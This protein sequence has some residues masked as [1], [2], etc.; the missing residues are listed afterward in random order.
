MDHMDQNFIAQHWYASIYDQFENFTHDVAFLLKV[1]S[2]QTDRKSLKIL[3]VACGTGRICIPLAEAGHAV[4]G[5]DLSEAALLRCLAKGKDLPNLTLYRADA[6]AEGWG[7]GYDVVVLA[8]NVFMNIEGAGDYA[9]AQRLF[10]RRA[11]DALRSGGHLYL[12]F[13]VHQ[14]PNA[15]AGDI[16]T[17]SYFTGTDELGTT[18]RT[19]RYGTSADPVQRLW[20]GTGHIELTL[21]NGQPLMI[22]DN[23]RKYIPTMPQIL[24]WLAEAGL[25]ASRTYRDFTDAPVE[26]DAQESFRATIWAVKER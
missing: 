8:G 18:G 14:E 4:T 10:L 6:L 15:F 7:E 25:T 2:E 20:M 16:K 3:E 5:F 21:A 22:P 9:Q 23:W 12:D 17:S 26:V 24:D 19:I 13:D 1:L 11:S